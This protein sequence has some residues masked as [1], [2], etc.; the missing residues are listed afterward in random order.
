VNDP[1]AFVERRATTGKPPEFHF[2]SVGDNLAGIISEI[3]VVNGVYGPFKVISVIT[4][5]GEECRFAATGAVLSSRLVNVCVGDALGIRRVAD[6]YSPEH[7]KAYPAYEV[8]R[9]A[10]ENTL[11]PTPTP[12]RPEIAQ[13]LD[14]TFG[15][16]DDAELDF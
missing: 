3:E 10:C 7:K 14:E 2:D 8:T 1:L 11:A 15:D 4:R 5:A 16:E 12:V 9:V 13:I 6:G